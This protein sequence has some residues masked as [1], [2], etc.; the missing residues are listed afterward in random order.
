M[1]VIDRPVYELAN[2][3]E[4][5]EV[6][7]EELAMEFLGRI[8]RVD[9]K[10]GAFVTVDREGTLS[11][12]RSVDRA[13][14]AG[15]APSRLAGIPVAVKDNMCTRGIETT[16]SSKMLRG[17]V[18]PYDAHVVERVKA[19]GMLVIGKTNLDEF[20]GTSTGFCAVRPKT[21]NWSGSGRIQRL[22][23]TVAAR[24]SGSLDLTLE[25]CAGATRGAWG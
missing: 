10:I 24:G 6:S 4:A 1:D 22:G 23:C 2:L 3:L 14:R 11:G 25:I 13:R 5:G 8:D 16:C 17:F 9:G 18:P 19:A 21:W 7:A 15:E 20:P 12:A